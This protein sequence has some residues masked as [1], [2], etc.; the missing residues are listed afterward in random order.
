MTETPK[1]KVE[2]FAVKM[3]DLDREVKYLINKAKV[4][5]P[6]EKPKEEKSESKTEKNNT[7]TKGEL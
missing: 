1:V 7:E 2:D 6:K 3:S 4:Y 5:R